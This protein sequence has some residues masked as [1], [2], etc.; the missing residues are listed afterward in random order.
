MEN[1]IDSRCTCMLSI[2]AESRLLRLGDSLLFHGTPPILS[3]GQYSRCTFWLKTLKI[4]YHA[5]EAASPPA[6]RLEPSEA[7][8]PRRAGSFLRH[9]DLAQAGGCD[10]R[11]RQRHLPCLQQRWCRYG[12]PLGREAARRIGSSVKPSRDSSWVSQP[13]SHPAGGLKIEQFQRCDRFGVLRI[14]GQNSIGGVCV[15]D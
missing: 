5:M 4:T 9:T 14:R 2:L 1:H 15:S 13:N 3:T 8:A 11:P 10:R 7:G 12:T 6:L